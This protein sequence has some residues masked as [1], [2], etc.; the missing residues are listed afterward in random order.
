MRPCYALA[1]LALS[2]AGA[3]DDAQATPCALAV[4]V[5]GYLA[6]AAE[7]A[8][9]RL[10]AATGCELTLADS[11]MPLTFVPGTIVNELGEPACGDSLIAT[12]ASG[13]VLE[14]RGME[15]DWTSRGCPTAESLIIH[16]SMHVLA[17]PPGSMYDG[18]HGTDGVFS[19]Y[20]TADSSPRLT[21][22]SLE[23]FCSRAAC[24][25]FVPEL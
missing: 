4:S 23:F 24:T 1:L 21:A 16:E 17:N 14:S 22:G 5:P 11:G 8:A 6:P 13:R 10:R 12:V 3:T 15:I 7:G 9:E 25:A 19:D 20:Q 18:G 2:C